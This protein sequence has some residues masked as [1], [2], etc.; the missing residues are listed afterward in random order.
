MNS[1]KTLVFS[2]SAFKTQ[3]KGE[4]QNPYNSLKR[5]PVLNFLCFYW[6]FQPLLKAECGMSAKDYKSCT[7]A[8]PTRSSSKD[9][10]PSIALSLA[11]LGPL[12]KWEKKS[13]CKHRDIQTAAEFKCTTCMVHPGGC[14]PGY[15]ANTKAYIT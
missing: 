2:S 14:C 7:I 10:L 13:P 3:W 9:C 12:V 4:T 11:F 8:N 5:N 6:S 1:Q 15:S